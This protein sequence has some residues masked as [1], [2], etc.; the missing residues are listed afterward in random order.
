MMKILS[1]RTMRRLTSS[2]ADGNIFVGTQK[3]ENQAYSTA[4]EFC[5]AI[6]FV[7]RVQTA[8]A[9]L[10]VIKNQSEREESWKW[11]ILSE[12]QVVENRTREALF[13]VLANMIKDID[14]M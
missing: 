8:I 7:V 2:F 10:R 3:V 1:F 5:R 11:L 14:G 4:F 13:I 9:E 6:T 12:M